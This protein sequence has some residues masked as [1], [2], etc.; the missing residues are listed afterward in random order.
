[1]IQTDQLLAML[2]LFLESFTSPGGLLGHF[3]YALLILSMLMRRMLPLRI[4]AICSGLASL[5]FDLI[6]INNPV[7]AF[8]DLALVLANVGQLIRM[9]ISAR[10]AVFSAEEKQFLDMMMPGLDKTHARRLLNLGCWIDGAAGTGLTV[11]GE[12]VE[13]LIFLL[14]GEASVRRDDREIAKCRAGSFIGEMTVLSGDPATGTVVLSQPSRYLSLN[15]KSLR[16]LAFS[17][18]D[19]QQALNAAFSSNMREKLVTSNQALLARQDKTSPA[20]RVR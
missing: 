2:D 9:A 10:R 16:K 15:A 19:I 17:S 12:P 8:W 1:M 5:A 14:N 7:G 3:S 11:E 4:L 20:G 6:W 13:D 18:A